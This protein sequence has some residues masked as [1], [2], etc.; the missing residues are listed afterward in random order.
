MPSD[1]ISNESK[2][3]LAKI[4][5]R[6]ENVPEWKQLMTGWCNYCNH[7]AKYQKGK[8]LFRRAFGS[9]TNGVSGFATITTW[10]K[11]G[12]IGVV[13]WA[14]KVATAY[15]KAD[16]EDKTLLGPKG[17]FSAALAN[18]LN[19]YGK[20]T[21]S[22]LD[23][24]V[25]DTTSDFLDVNG[26]L[27]MRTAKILAKKSDKNISLTFFPKS[28]Q[29]FLKL[30]KLTAN[31]H[32]LEKIGKSYED[33][34]SK[35]KDNILTDDLNEELLNV[36]N[37]KDEKRKAENEISQEQKEID[38]RLEKFSMKREE[39]EEEQEEE[40]EKISEKE[41]NNSLPSE[42][43][44]ENIKANIPLGYA[45]HVSYIQ[46]ETLKIKDFYSKTFSG[47]LKDAL[48]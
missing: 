46:K 5:M 8:N 47:K 16:D 13:R 11:I 33:W 7:I 2:M 41:P 20:L 17:M 31:M 39:E 18:T 14:A 45:K 40:E 35:L 19:I 30:S 26:E 6:K 9:W 29:F 1:N 34:K 24:W 22:K 15:S 27:L 4:S 25:E 3:I 42:N 37:N 36:L 28:L 48:K 23:N 21:L 10:F 12:K 44:E 43:I 38:K 32:A